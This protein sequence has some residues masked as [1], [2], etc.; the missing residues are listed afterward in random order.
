MKYYKVVPEA[1]DPM[2]ATEGSACFDIKALITN[3]TITYY[4]RSNEKNK[5]E[6]K[7]GVEFTILP[8]YRV[9]VPTGLIFDIPNGHSVRIHARSGLSV[10]KGLTLANSEG[11]IDSDY[12]EP[13][14]VPLINLSSVDVVI[15]H[16]ERIC[17][18][19][20]VKDHPQLY[21][22]STDEKPTR[23]VAHG[24]GFGSTGTHGI[25]SK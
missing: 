15:M 10:K 18:G 13:V 3:Q 21:L 22:Q 7:D 20:E 19:E 2:Y 16:G 11:I 8:G 24:S 1:Y 5:F 23:E 14:F 17:Q 9:L 25:K 6:A 12:V 4:N